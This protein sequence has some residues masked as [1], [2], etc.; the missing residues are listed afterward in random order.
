M[1]MA[2]VFA[3][4]VLAGRY[5]MA[6]LKSAGWARA[7]LLRTHQADG[8]TDYDPIDSV[9]L[10]LGTPSALGTWA[11]LGLWRRG[12]E[13]SGTYAQAC[14]RLTRAVAEA[15][16]LCDDR[17]A[18][19]A[20]RHPL[21]RNSPAS[22]RGG[23]STSSL[24]L[25]DVGFGHGDELGYLAKAFAPASI[26]GVNA[27]MAEVAAARRRYGCDSGAALQ[28]GG[29][30]SSASLGSTRLTL[31]Y[32]SA[33]SLVE[34]VPLPGFDAVLCVDAAYHFRP[35]RAKFFA[36]A[37]S[38]LNDGGTLALA[39]ICV[40]EGGAH[41]RAGF[42]WLLALLRRAALAL[43]CWASG[44]PIQNLVTVEEYRVQMEEAGF[45]SAR[46]E[47][48][49]SEEGATRG[50]SVFGGFADFVPR[51]QCAWARQMKPAAWSH[52]RGAAAFCRWAER[53]KALHFVIASARLPALSPKVK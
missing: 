15:A 4:G 27:C 9:P 34:T 52:A 51:Q 6:V 3:L 39:D 16:L 36:Q 53:S 44:V 29:Q 2:A 48:V 49:G 25:L 18:R 37:S 24:R 11:N 12:D 13:G 21:E 23:G 8:L 41:G 40:A 45:E 26:V 30:Q 31:L 42:G 1:P 43:A 35:S 38:V 46:V 22:T 32:G 47:V 19:A 7:K 50:C 20:H 28:L 33:T 5:G 17:D 10:N 14:E